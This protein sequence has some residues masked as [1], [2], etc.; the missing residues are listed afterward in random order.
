M[1]ILT[2]KQNFEGV[3]LCQFGTE[4]KDENVKQR[5]Q[6]RRNDLRL[7]DAKNNRST[8]ASKWQFIALLRSP[9]FLAAKLLLESP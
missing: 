5:Q 2:C 8:S 6:S 7:F 1:P 3:S 4:A 9:G